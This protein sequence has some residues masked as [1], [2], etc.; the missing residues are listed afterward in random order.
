MQI[1]NPITTICH[2]LVGKAH[3]KGHRILIGTIILI[4]GVIINESIVVENS[5]LQLCHE[6]SVDLLKAV[7][8]IPYIEHVLEKFT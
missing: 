3:T 7:G 5:I 1:H 6:A 4:I 8:I 2:H